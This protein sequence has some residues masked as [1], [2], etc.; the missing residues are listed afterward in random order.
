MPETKVTVIT[1]VFNGVKDIEHTLMNVL[2]Q[3]YPNMEYIIVDGG[4]T[5]GTMDI[6]GK[7]RHRLSHCISEKDNG[8]YDAMNKGVALATG[9]WINFMNCGDTFAGTKTV[10]DVMAFVKPDDEFIYGDYIADYENKGRR[11]IKAG[12]PRPPHL[13]ILS[14]QSVFA[15]RTLLLKYPFDTRFKICADLQFYEECWHHGH[16]M[17]Y[18]PHAVS[19]RSQAGVSDR[20]RTQAF[21]ESEQ[22]LRKFY[23][24]SYV[25]SLMQRIRF[26]HMLK[27]GSKKI[28][29]SFLQRMY[30]MWM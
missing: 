8:I 6:I 25:V 10:E 9:K 13:M 18:Y 1:V 23:S 29:P 27:H 11:F 22:V 17:R 30:R 14:H 21:R 7:Y 12:K 16:A 19:V 2:E 26:I 28:M 24:A 5:D 3:S 4:S 20:N 15:S